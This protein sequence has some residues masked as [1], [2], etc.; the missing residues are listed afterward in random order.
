[1]DIQAL[2]H[3]LEPDYEC[4]NM[5]QSMAH[6]RDPN[7]PRRLD[8]A[9][10]TKFEER[11]D[12]KD[13][14]REIAS[15]TSEIAGEPELHKELTAERAKIYSRKSKC[16]EAW[17]K[18][19]IQNWWHAAYEEYISGNEFTERDTTTLFNIYQ[20]Y[21]PERARLKQ[22]LFTETS[23]DSVIGQQ[24]LEDM[25]ALCTSTE[26]VAYY[27]GLLPEDNRCPICSK[28]ISQCVHSIACSRSQY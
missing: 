4:R 26:R 5:E 12:I 15:L 24:C 22:S 7:A 13:M 14:N 2:F 6:H 19:F 17:K 9:A 21:L 23:L 18:E 20:K 16:L 11:D 10:I 27:P 28:I 8:A 25:V 3:D 1:L